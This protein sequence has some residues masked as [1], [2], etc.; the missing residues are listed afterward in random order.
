MI[1]EDLNCSS[2]RGSTLILTLDALGGLGTH[3][4]SKC[5]RPRTARR[6]AV[7]EAVA[8]RHRQ[9]L[10][11]WKVLKIG[12][13]IRIYRKLWALKDYRGLGRDSSKIIAGLLFSV[14]DLQGCSA[15][16]A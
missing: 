13:T 14:Q 3:G 4:L 2:R 5:R 12:V 6:T 11:V 9:G 8:C 15:V 16:C 7:C 10:R 1:L